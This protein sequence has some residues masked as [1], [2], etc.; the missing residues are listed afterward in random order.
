MALDVVRVTVMGGG[1]RKV[2]TRDRRGAVT[3]R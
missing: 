1:K 2:A 3:D